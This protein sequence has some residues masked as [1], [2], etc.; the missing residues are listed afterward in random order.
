MLKSCVGKSHH[1]EQRTAK[2]LVCWLLIKAFSDHYNPP[3]FVNKEASQPSSPYVDTTLKMNILNLKDQSIEKENLTSSSIRPHLGGGGSNVDFPGA[4]VDHPPEP[5]APGLLHPTQAL[6]GRT[7]RWFAQWIHL[8]EDSN[9]VFFLFRRGRCCQSEID[10]LGG[11]NYHT[12]CVFFDIIH[13]IYIF[14]DTYLH[15]TKAIVYCKCNLCTCIFNAVNHECLRSYTYAYVCI[16]NP[17]YHSQPGHKGSDAGR[18]SKELMG[19]VQMRD[20]LKWSRAVFS[21]RRVVR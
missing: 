18:Q 17:I 7:L 15:Y 10:R 4:F 5:G 6:L 16:C 3:V 21:F 9:L 11:Q 19:L 2:D 20:F 12:V 14:F 13:C 1:L 8:C